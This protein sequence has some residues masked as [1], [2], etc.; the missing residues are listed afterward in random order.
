MMTSLCN[1]G[2]GMAFMG[3]FG[4]LFLALLVLGVVALIKYIFF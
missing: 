4:L 2:G 3:L 1:W